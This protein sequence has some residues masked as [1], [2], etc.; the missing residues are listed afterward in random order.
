MP[1]TAIQKMVED[2]GYQKVCAK[3]VPRQ[4]TPDLKERRVKVCSELLEAFEANEDVLGNLVTGDEIWLYV[5][6]LE[7]RF[8]PWNSVRP[9][10]RALKI[11]EAA[12]S[13]ESNGD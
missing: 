9:L 11:E 1:Y 7:R 6:D 3:W 4:L 8:G 13:T 2:L 10:L 12:F 5:Y